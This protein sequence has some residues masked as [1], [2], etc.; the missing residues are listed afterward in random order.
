MG[1]PENNSVLHLKNLQLL[2]TVQLV[3]VLGTVPTQ[4]QGFALGLVE[5]H[6]CTDLSLS[7]SEVC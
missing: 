1:S 7:I 5:Q 3:F 4:V 6:V 2:L